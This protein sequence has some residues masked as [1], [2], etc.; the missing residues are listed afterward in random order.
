[1][2][3]DKTDLEHVKALLADGFDNFIVELMNT[4]DELYDEL[5]KLLEHGADEAHIHAVHIKAHGLKSVGRQCGLVRLGQLAREME[6]T[7]IE[8][9]KDPGSYSEAEWRRLRGEYITTLA[10][11]RTELDKYTSG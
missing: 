1:M 4:A 2:L 3:V 10:E 9:K 5:E 6:S 8:N 7:A 11:T